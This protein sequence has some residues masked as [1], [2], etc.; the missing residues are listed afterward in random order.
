MMEMRV[1]KIESEEQLVSELEKK[2]TSRKESIEAGLKEISEMGRMLGAMGA[3]QEEI[4]KVVNETM[5]QFI[6]DIVS[7]L[8]KEVR[9]GKLSLNV[10]G[11]IISAPGPIK[12]L[13]EKDVAESKK[14]LAKF[15]ED[16]ENLLTLLEGSS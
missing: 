5:L 10:T 4:A 15:E 13:M 14:L 8:R 16:L 12:D 7:G 6:K 1:V 11:S 3:S 9:Y 2:N